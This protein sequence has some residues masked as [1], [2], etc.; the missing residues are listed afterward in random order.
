MTT[1]I[2]KAHRLLRWH[3]LGPDELRLRMPWAD[4]RVERGTACARYPYV[5]RS[6]SPVEVEF[7][8]TNI[9][10]DDVVWDVGA[11]YGM[12][13]T[14]AASLAFEGQ[15]FAFEPDPRVFHQLQK[16]ARAHHNLEVVT[17]ALG[18]R[19]GT[20]WLRQ[21]EHRTRCASLATDEADGQDV[22]PV[23]VRSGDSLVH[24]WA[25]RPDVLKIDVDGSELEVLDG[26]NE[27][28]KLARGC[29]VEPH[30]PEGH[31]RVLDVA[32]RLREAGMMVSVES[33]GRQVF[34]T[35][36]R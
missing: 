12:F 17:Y 6:W 30:T 32:Q 31:G 13:S 23:P 21:P 29:V 28:L 1:L 36:T 15:V 7:A 10:P 22:R 20:G 24:A 35:G 8:R 34:V 11:N 16:N 3:G 27:T 25:P 5:W 9:R 4:L 19:E 14:L 33:D 18:R 2:G 26:M